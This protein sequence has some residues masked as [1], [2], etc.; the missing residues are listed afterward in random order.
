M[1]DETQPLDPAHTTRSIYA[2][3]AWLESRIGYGQD[4]W[5]SEQIRLRRIWLD[6]IRQHRKAENAACRP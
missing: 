5:I 3:I 1:D 4:P 6:Q 2:D